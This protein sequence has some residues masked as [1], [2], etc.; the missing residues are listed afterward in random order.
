[1]MTNTHKKA[2]LITLW[3]VAFA[4]LMASFFLTAALPL[5][6]LLMPPML[7]GMASYCY[8]NPTPEKAYYRLSLM[9]G[10]LSLLGC[11][12]VLATALAITPYGLMCAGLACALLPSWLWSRWRL[13]NKPDPQ[14]TSQQ[15]LGLLCGHVL[16]LTLAIPAIIFAAQSSLAGLLLPLACSAF[17]V[18]LIGCYMA[19]TCP[20]VNQPT[21][22]AKVTQETAMTEAH[23]KKAEVTQTTALMQA[24]PP[25]KPRTPAE[26][27]LQTL[28]AV[29]RGG[30][31]KRSTTSNPAGASTLKPNTARPSIEIDCTQEER[32]FAALLFKYRQL[33]GTDCSTY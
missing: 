22:K 8:L 28:G 26:Q 18:H 10:L 24:L 9:V 20:S 33:S 2:L 1:M 4:P 5:L 15:K 13:K 11:L 21:E 17:L 32:N 6:S 14:Y 16:L 3:L 23:N 19:R 27:T 7:M 12:P 30:D 29:A 31:D 25:K